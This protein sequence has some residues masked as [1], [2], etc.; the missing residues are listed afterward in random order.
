MEV[1]DSKVGK[2]ELISVGKWLP[3]YSK[4]IKRYR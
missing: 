4:T 2:R 3:K 1:F